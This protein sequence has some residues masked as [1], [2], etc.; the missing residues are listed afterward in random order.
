MRVFS[1]QS[2]IVLIAGCAHALGIAWPFAFLS[3]LGLTQGQPVWWLQLLAISLLAWQLDTAKTKRQ[4]AWV[5]WLFATVMQV[6]TWWWLYISLHTYGA[7]SYTHLR[8]HET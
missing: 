7:V 4:G 1:H 3:G 5:G 6:A 8:A 2:A